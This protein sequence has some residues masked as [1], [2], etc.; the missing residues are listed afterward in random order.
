M[1]VVSKCTHFSDCELIKRS[2]QQIYWETVQMCSRSSWHKP[3]LLNGQIAI[4]EVAAHVVSSRVEWVEHSTVSKLSPFSGNAGKWYARWKADP[5]TYCR[6]PL[7]RYNCPSNWYQSRV[8]ISREDV[9][10]A[11]PHAKVETSR[12]Q[13]RI[14]KKSCDRNGSLIV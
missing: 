7:G 13:V 6:I 14:G 4:A 12:G 5:G 8:S 2:L 1:F 3:I 9:E 11:S 10:R